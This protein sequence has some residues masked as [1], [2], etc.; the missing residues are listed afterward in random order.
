MFLQ[1]DY[2]CVDFIYLF[3]YVSTRMM[4]R[5]YCVILYSDCVLVLRKLLLLH[6]FNTWFDLYFSDIQR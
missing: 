1:S 6:I 3:M 4:L 2:V 5:M